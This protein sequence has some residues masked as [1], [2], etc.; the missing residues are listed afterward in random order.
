V[1]VFFKL[2]RQQRKEQKEWSSEECKRGDLGDLAQKIASLRIRNPARTELAPSRPIPMGQ[3]DF[4]RVFGVFLEKDLREVAVNRGLRRNCPPDSRSY[5]MQLVARIDAYLS[6]LDVFMLK[7]VQADE[8][9]ARIHAVPERIHAEAEDGS[10]ISDA[11][12]AGYGE[13][14]EYEEKC[15]RKEIIDVHRRSSRQRS[16]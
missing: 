8:A 7:C 14:A 6:S 2:H 1:Q 9:H 5:N 15:L 4:F 3:R 12:E 11:G 10:D 16:T 13:N